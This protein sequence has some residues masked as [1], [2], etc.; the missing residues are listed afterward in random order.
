MDA[1][2]DHPLGD[3]VL[4]I[5]TAEQQARF[6]GGGVRKLPV[7]VR[8]LALPAKDRSAIGP[9]GNAARRDANLQ[10]GRLVEGEERTVIDAWILRVG[11]TA[12]VDAED[13]GAGPEE[14]I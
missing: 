8:R 9:R 3:L 5:P 14:R 2:D 4:A 6:I 11:H 13:A 12:A 7:Q 1:F 10:L